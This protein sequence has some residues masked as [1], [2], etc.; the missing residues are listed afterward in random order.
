MYKKTI[1]YEDYDGEK[2]TETHYFNMTKA[3]VVK[4]ITTNGEYTLDKVVKRDT[5]SGN[6]KAII[7]TF[8]DLIKR[9]YGRK[10]LDGKRF[11]K[12]EE[13][14]KEFYESEAY[15]EFFMEIITDAKAAA[16]FFNGIMPKNVLEE[17]R[18]IARTNPEAI[19]EEARPLITPV[20]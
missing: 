13:I 12:S 8:E 7:E 19:P 10:S 20:S 15:S 16:D 3:D 5:L 6:G 18:E 2:R 14:Y 11:E 4:W 17:A 1:T 9:S